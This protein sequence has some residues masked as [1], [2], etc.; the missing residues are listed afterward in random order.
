MKNLKEKQDKHLQPA[1][2]E[3]VPN[4]YKTVQSFR[5]MGYSNYDAIEDLIDNS[6]DA[7]ATKILIKIASEDTDEI[8]SRGRPKK[9]ISKIIVV[10]NGC[11]KM[12]SCL[13]AARRFCIPT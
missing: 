3:L 8:G 10:D 1:T 11:G 12:L 7:G 5:N 13:F 2:I 4:A 9:T 6:L